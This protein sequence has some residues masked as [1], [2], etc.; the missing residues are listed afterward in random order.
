MLLQKLATQHIGV[1]NG[2]GDAVSAGSRNFD[3]TLLYQ[4]FIDRVAKYVGKKRAA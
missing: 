1:T 3:S 2:E 4:S